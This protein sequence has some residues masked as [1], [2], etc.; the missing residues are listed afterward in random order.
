MST[1]S[2]IIELLDQDCTDG[3]I[4]KF[5]GASGIDFY[6]EEFTLWAFGVIG[7]LYYSPNQRYLVVNSPRDNVNA[8][9]IRAIFPL[10]M[11]A[12]HIESDLISSELYMFDSLFISLKEAPETTE[13]RNH[14]HSLVSSHSFRIEDGLSDK[15]LASFIYSDTVEKPSV[16]KRRC[17]VKLTELINFEELA[18]VDTLAM[19]RQIFSQYK[20]NIK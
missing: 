1:R 6:N 3:N 9:F 5:I 12:L 7:S 8:K 18:K 11:M 17:L 14:F 15:R 2:Q 10:E 16:F 19:W 13:E 20:N 4:F